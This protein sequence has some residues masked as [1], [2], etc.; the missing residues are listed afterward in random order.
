[1]YAAFL[2]SM[3]DLLRIS[4]QSLFLMIISSISFAYSANL[5]RAQVV[6][7]S[8]ANIN[9]GTVDFDTTYNG[10]IQLGTDGNVQTTGFGLVARDNG[11]AGAIQV[12][13]PDT[14]ILELKCS[15]T[16]QLTDPT[17]TDLDIVNVEIAVNTGVAFSS[18]V[19]CNGVGGGDAVA[20]TLDMD[21][22]GDPNI[23]IGGE[24]AITGAITLPSDRVY[25]TTG[26][27]T[28]I[29]LSIVVQ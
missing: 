23:F 12:T 29:Q 5:A 7:N 6:I 19:D 20:T 13:S 25:N 10:N 17:A 24:I 26:S 27:G 28:P 18:G 14:G 4:Y 3:V 2:L 15:S 22:L 21:A 11:N 1:M 16:A 8:N 9:F